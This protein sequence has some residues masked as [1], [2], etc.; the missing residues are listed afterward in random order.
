M[1]TDLKTENRIIDHTRRR[2]D[3]FTRRFGEAHLNLARHAAFP[4]ALT[5]DLVY[6]LW[7]NFQHDVNNKFLAIP[8]EA[9]SDLLLSALC[10][11]VGY[12]LYELDLAVRK[13]LLKQLQSDPRFGQ[14]RIEELAH[15]LHNYVWQQ[16]NSPD[17]DLRDFARVQRWMAL[18]H[19]QPGR[20]A[21]ELARTLADLFPTAAGTGRQNH[22]ELIRTTSLVQTLAEPL[23]EYQPLLSYAEGL[24]RLARG[25]LAEATHQFETIA[26]SSD[27]F[28]DVAGVQLPLPVQVSDEPEPEP[29]SKQPVS[30]SETVKFVVGG[31][32]QV[33]DGTYLERPADT[34]LYQVCKQGDFAYVLGSRQIGKSSLMNSTEQKLRG[35]GI[36]TAV[37]DLTS[38]GSATDEEIWY[39]SLTTELS[40]RLQLK[41]DVDRWWNEQP[42]RLSS[43]QQ[44]QL[45][46]RE[47]VFEEIP[48]SIVVFIDE[49]DFTLGLDFTDGF[50]A[51]IRSIYQ[52]RA[53]DEKYKRLTFVLLGT[54]TPDELISN[55]RYTPFNIGKPINLQDFTKDECLLLQDGIEVVHPQQAKDYFNQIYHWTNGHPYLTQKLCDAVVQTTENDPDL[56]DRIVDN[57]FFTPE[58]RSEH[59]IQFVQ[60]SIIRDRYAQAMLRIYKRVIDGQ[61][62]ANDEFS[63]AI[64]RLKLYGILVNEHGQLKV[65]NKIYAQAFH[66]DWADEMLKSIRL[67]L[68][69]KYT[70]LQRIDQR[71]FITVYLAQTEDN[72]ER[73]TVAL[74]VLKVPE[75]AEAKWVTWL[76]QLES[77]ARNV[78]ST[79]HPNIVQILDMGLVSEKTLFIVMDYVVGGSLRDKLEKGPLSRKEAMDVARQIGTALTHVHANGI[80]HLAVN[81]N[82]ILLDNRETP[83]KWML[84]DFGLVK[85]LLQDPQ[86]KLG[87]KDM[88]TGLYIAPEKEEMTELTPAV[89]IYGLAVTFFE[90]IVGQLPEDRKPGDP[91]PSASELNPDI[92]P[93]FDKVLIRATDLNPD[94]RFDTVADFVEAL[95][96]ANK[97]T[98]EVELTEKEMRAASVID[99]V[100]SYMGEQNYDPEKALLMIDRVLEIN[101]GHG[102][103]LLLRGRIRLQQGMIDEALANYE[104][105]YEQDKELKLDAGIEYLKVLSQLAD[106]L[107]QQGE[108]DESARCYEAVLQVFSGHDRNNEVVARI[109]QATRSRLIEYHRGKAEGAYNSEESL[110]KVL[111]V[112]E[113]EMAE[114]SNLQAESE[115][116]ALKER[117]K[118]LQIKK[119]REMIDEARVV[120]A[121]A[122]LD[123]YDYKDEDIFQNFAT[124][125]RA[126]QA[127]IQLE[128]D[129]AQWVNERHEMLKQQIKIRASFA[130]LARGQPEPN[131]ETALQYYR[132][133]ESIEADLPGITQELEIDFATEIEDLRIKVDHA[134]KYQKIQQLIAEKEYER[135]LERL[136]LDFIQTGNTEYRDVAKLLWMMVYAAREGKLPPEAEV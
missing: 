110:D 71:G 131:Y 55:N 12:E 66:K 135:A 61:S 13:V 43:T 83:S 59:N 49:I 69:E 67:D 113:H 70:I 126:Y 39:Y 34:E 93:H 28:V 30:E 99:G 62:I 86:A 58:A 46:L 73:V 88:Q 52:K 60:S 29:E 45:F 101:P 95:E 118:L 24:T 94:D 27:R 98:K 41:T 50:F 77:K 105:A 97:I 51:A 26:E 75:Q 120:I 117:F 68:P 65:R 38:I 18:S 35:E 100:H 23:R 112:F 44:F 9:V 25:D 92:G 104:Q 116:D 87:S 123:N 54:A 122:N 63:P 79:S 114:L 42:S 56:V 4:L 32:V 20:A 130:A 103:A 115:V 78:A 96:E 64:S 128:P 36:R 125:D 21:E 111:G 2:L 48:E 15:F 89:D 91:L 53:Q 72:D 19:L 134:G 47:V 82:D 80:Y 81:P 3:A 17:P 129:N 133:I 16:L 107:W 31:T 127:L 121:Q 132:A 14:P 102:E 7:A 22:A 37:I 40:Y 1:A 8:W 5:P 33:K 85:Y 108:F 74:K 109:L 90:A 119:Y 84:T 11:E 136:K 57:I 76:E 6:R 10:D 124:A 106:R